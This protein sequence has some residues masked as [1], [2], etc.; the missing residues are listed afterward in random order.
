[1]P[2]KSDFKIRIDRMAVADIAE[3]ALTSHLD[4][5]IAKLILSGAPKYDI[6]TANVIVAFER[7]LINRRCEPD[8]TVVINE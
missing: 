7:Y 6:D 4:P 3:A 2:G 8:F 5:A 1:M